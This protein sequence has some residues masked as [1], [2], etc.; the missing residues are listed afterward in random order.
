[1]LGMRDI[2]LDSSSFSLRL[3]LVSCSNQTCGQIERRGK[4]CGSL[5]KR[6]NV[7][8][9]NSI[10]MNVTD[11]LKSTVYI[12]MRAGWD[13]KSSKEN[14]LIGSRNRAADL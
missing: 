4:Q 6:G 9:I 13:L 10:L 2:E 5:H 12:M 8:L 3:L 11:E 1:M 7:C 14:D